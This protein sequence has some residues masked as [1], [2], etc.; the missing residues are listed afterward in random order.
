MNAL[1]W[2]RIALVLV[3]FAAGATAGWGLNGWRLNSTVADVRIQ[4][5]NSE[6]RVGIL[7][8]AN[9]KCAVDV[10]DVRQAYAD[11]KAAEIKR[12]AAARVALAKAELIAAA[13][14]ATAR[15][16]MDAPR[17]AAGQECQAIVQEEHDYVQARQKR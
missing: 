10:A 12:A 5:A 13:N 8:P 7:E 17:P 16:I 1:P 4:L 9:A 14:T 6:T 15:L 2:G 3:I 11:L